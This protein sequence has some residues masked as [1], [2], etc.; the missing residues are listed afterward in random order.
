ML[1][2]EIAGGAG[3]PQ[4]SQ[5]HY[6]RR[7]TWGKVHHKPRSTIGKGVERHNPL[8]HL[9]KASWLGELALGGGGCTPFPSGQAVP[10]SASPEA[11]GPESQGA[12][13]K[14]VFLLGQAEAGRAQDSENSTATRYPAS[15][16]DQCTGACPQEHLG[17]CVLGAVVSYSQGARLQSWKSGRYHFC[18]SSVS[19]CA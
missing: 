12:K 2:Q 9:G 5:S 16:A 14:R 6:K 4:D 8:V 18:F 7:G 3:K 10:R 13:A 15:C 17:Q 11:Q 1:S 19:P